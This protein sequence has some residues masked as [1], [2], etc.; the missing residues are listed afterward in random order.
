MRNRGLIKSLAIVFSFASLLLLSQP[1]TATHQP[2]DKVF[3]SA[4]T[5]EVTHAQLGPGTSAAE[6]D[7]LEAVL[8]TSSPTDLLL[9]VTAE[10]ALVTDFDPFLVPTSETVATV[11][12]WVE[13]D[14]VPVPVT[15]DPAKGGPDNGRVVFCNRDFRIDQ[16]LPISITELFIKTRSANAFNWG[17]LN[18]GSGIHTIKVRARLEGTVSTAGNAHAV[19]GKRTLVVEPSKMANDITI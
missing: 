12:V 14:G 9:N 15:S 16:L 7:L 13:I 18:V 3:A 4:S 17:A 2:A 5:L 1:A 11:E 8:R 6:F 10:C 19:V